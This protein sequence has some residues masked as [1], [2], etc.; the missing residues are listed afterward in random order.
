MPPDEIAALGA[1]FIDRTRIYRKTD[2]PLFIDK[3]P[4]NWA[5]I[6]LIHLI[7][8]HAKIIDARRHPMATCFSAFKQH[9]AR[10]QNFSYDL[11][12]LG[13]Y[14]NDY[15]AMLHHFDTALPGRIHR[16][17]YETMVA[18][19]ET[20]TQNLLAYCNLPFEPAC[21]RFWE[22]DRPVR[23]ASSEQVR[24]PIF[25]EGLDHWRNYA[26]WLGTLEKALK[27]GQGSALD[28]LGP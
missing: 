16:V 18:N 4:N 28:P 20:E 2:K 13:R 8:P 6:G 26:P 27:E 23:T 10:G 11:T 9:F 14:Y 5:H 7:L 15:V 22:T 17:Q 24:Q 1:R 21:L 25:R 19:T 3:M 12:E